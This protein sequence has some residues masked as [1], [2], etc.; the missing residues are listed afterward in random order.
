MAL[1]FQV[2]VTGAAAGAVYGLVAVGHSLVYRLTGVVNFAYGG[3]VGLAVFPPLLVAAGAGPVT[4]AGLGGAR[5]L[6]ALVAGVLVCTA[7]SAG[8]YLF[9]IQPYLKRGSTVGW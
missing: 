5:F 3:L 7:A 2:L 8:T 4:Q 1:A 9:A 6:V